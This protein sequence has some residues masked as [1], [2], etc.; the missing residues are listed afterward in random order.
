[1][2][3]TTTTK[4]LA[5]LSNQAYYP[6]EAIGNGKYKKQTIN[7]IE[8]EPLEYMDNKATGYQGTI[9]QNVKTGEIVVAHRGTESPF[10]D[11]G[12]PK[13]ALTD[14]G[15]VLRRV[16]AQAPDAE[17][18]TQHSLEWAKKYAKGHPNDPVPSVTVT[19]HSLGGTLAEITASR[20]G[21]RAE[22]FNA[23]GAA[24]LIDSRSIPKDGQPII[25]HVMA[26][27]P[28]SAA[29]A[30]IGEVRMYATAKEVKTIG[31][32]YSNSDSLF[33]KVVDTVI[34]PQSLK[35]ARVVASAANSLDSH[36]ISKFY[37]ED[38]HGNRNRGSIL[39]DPK[40]QQRAAENAN[41]FNHYRSDVYTARAV[42]SGAGDVVRVA[43]QGYEYAHQTATAAGNGVMQGAQVVEKKAEQA[44]DTTRD[45][46]VQGYGA[47]RDAVVQGAQAVEK[48]AE[49]VS[50][51][52]GDGAARAWDTLSHPGA[53]LGH[54]K[55]A[56]A[57]PA[58]PP[59]ASGSLGDGRGQSAQNGVEV[60]TGDPLVDKMLASL[61]DP[62]ALME[63][64]R[65]I[66]NSPHGEAIRAEG[67]E[68]YAQQ[69]LARQQARE[70]QAQQQSRE[71]LVR[72]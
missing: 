68:L 36:S 24:S 47:A 11:R 31:A 18:L 45:A 27:D 53:W 25:N 34:V 70:M 41:M 63:S 40:A 54:D 42:L 35:V 59:A 61:D 56:Q 37:N 44:Y 38:E 32:L 55:P 46:V 2:T 28:V 66:A 7:G 64:M 29:S 50:R 60:L 39:E 69:E 20:H 67:R 6:P 22:T 5:D 49:Q 65:A 57:Q 30:H 21:L 14:A 3:P 19:G 9:Y 13:D 51:T 43:G 8:Y 33:S 71:G 52:I 48:K 15:M 17:K 72:S 12:D 58:K 10:G 1:M 26:A 23:Y 4:D 62:V 16:N